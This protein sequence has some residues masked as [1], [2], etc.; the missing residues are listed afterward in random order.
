MGVAGIGCGPSRGW[1]VI[2]IV[3]GILVL[4]VSIGLGVW[5]IRGR[6]TGPEPRCPACDYVLFGVYT[7]RC[8]ECGGGLD[9]DKIETDRD[10]VRWLPL[11]IACLFFLTSILT[12][13]VPIGEVDWLDIAPFRVQVYLAEHG[14]KDALE[15][16]RNELRKGE[17]TLGQCSHLGDVCLEQQKLTQR[18]STP[19]QREW[20][21]LLQGLHFKGR[22][23]DQQKNVYFNQSITNVRLDVRPRMPAEGP[24]PIQLSLDQFTGHWS[25]TGEGMS[26][27]SLRVELSNERVRLRDD[28]NERFRDYFTASAWDSRSVA[29]PLL[30]DYGEH[31]FYLCRTLDVPAGKYSLIYT[32]TLEL[33]AEP[34]EKVVWSKDVEFTQTVR[35]DYSDAVV[36]ANVT[37]SPQDA[38]ML[39]RLISVQ[40]GN[41]LTMKPESLGMIS[42]CHADRILDVSLEKMTPISFAFDVEIVTRNGSYPVGWIAAQAGDSRIRSCFRE[43]ANTFID[44]SGKPLTHANAMIRLSPSVDAAR[45]TIS[46]A[47]IWNG[48]LLLGPIQIE[49][50]AIPA[51]LPPLSQP[52]IDTA[53]AD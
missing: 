39:Q 13:T 28:L 17:L 15:L 30:G 50:P 3:L 32:A 10:H 25:W 34:F 43:A 1:H 31:R 12:I 14:N 48:S 27:S 46:L 19:T 11:S 26:S 38:A 4:V 7:A 47:E 45:Q 44:V 6:R 36:I 35:V 29:R 41:W 42:G 24:F 33:L 2:Q 20:L 40:G 18:Q 8:P 21:N 52:S 5:S 16:I 9:W 53:P 51:P 22:L 37:P 23:S 49:L